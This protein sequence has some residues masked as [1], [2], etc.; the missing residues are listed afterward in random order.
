MVIKLF[1]RRTRK[2]HHVPHPLEWWWKLTQTARWSVKPSSTYMTKK[3]DTAPFLCRWADGLCCTDSSCHQTLAWS[4]RRS[5]ADTPSPLSRWF[6][7]NPGNISHSFAVSNTTRHL[8]RAQQMPTWNKTL[9]HTDVGVRW[10]MTY[11]ATKRLKEGTFAYLPSTGDYDL[12]IW[13]TLPVRIHTSA[14]VY[15]LTKGPGIC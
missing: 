7:C 1:L 13:L 10:G 14:Q 3:K 11:Y 8:P 6:L 12:S 5:S 4:W 15:H 2:I 9:L